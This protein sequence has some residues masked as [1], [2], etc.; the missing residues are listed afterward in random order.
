[1]TLEQTHKIIEILAYLF[2]ELCEHN[3]F[4]TDREYNWKKAEQIYKLEY[5]I[6]GETWLLSLLKD[7]KDE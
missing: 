2:N 4:K 1:M 7:K 5:E 6:N 3:N